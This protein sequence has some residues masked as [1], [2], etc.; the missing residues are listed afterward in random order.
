MNLDEALQ[1]LRGTALAD[2]RV[3]YARCM[4]PSFTTLERQYCSTA[5]EVIQWMTRCASDAG[6][7]LELDLIVLFSGGPVF[8]FAAGEELLFRVMQ[9]RSS[10]PRRS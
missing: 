6:Q 8:Q 3:W 7:S 2:G 4:N 10:P 5:D 1:T 9:R